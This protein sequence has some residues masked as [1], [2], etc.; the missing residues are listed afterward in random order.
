[1]R[2]A[3]TANG[4]GTS[5]GLESFFLPLADEVSATSDPRIID[6]TAKA[7]KTRRF[8]RRDPKKVYALVLHQM[9]CCFKVSDPLTRFL[10]MA[11]HFAILPDGRILQLHPILSLT[12]AS[13]GFNPG[14]VAVEFAGNFPDTRGKWWHGPQNGQNQVTAAQI[15]AGRYLVRHLMRTMGLKVIVAHRQSSGTRDNDPG[16]DI[17][18]HVGQWAVDNLGL[19]DG[20]PG[21]KTGTGKPIPDLWRTWGKVKPQPELEFSADESEAWESESNRSSSEYIRWVQQG[22][23]R[24]LGLRLAVDGIAGVQTKSAIR[25]FQTRQ[26]LVVDG[27][28][29]PVT[30]ASLVAAGAG[31]APGNSAPPV[32]GSCPAPTFVSCPGPGTTP[33]EVLDNFGHNVATLNRP[34]HTPRINRVAGQITASQSSRHPIRSILIAGHTDPT[35]SDRFNLDLARRRAEAV[36]QELCVAVGPSVARRLKFDLTSCGE[37]HL[38][39]TP[40][41]SRR[42]ELFLPKVP[43][44]S[45]KPPDVPPSAPTVPA[46]LE[47]LIRLVRDIL[48]GI[49]PLLGLTGAKLPTTARFLT[50]PEQA[51]AKKVFDGSLDFS[52]ILIADG[53]GF[54]N[55]KFT[56]AVPVSGRFHVVMLLGDLNPWHTH[57]R[58]ST[59]IHELAHAWQSQ[60]ANDATQFMKNS[61]SCQALALA[62]I[63]IA[64]A[65]AAAAAAARAAARGVLPWEIPGISKNAAANEDVSAYAYIPGKTFEA[66]AAEQIAQQ[67]ED[68]HARTGRPTPGVLSTIKSVRAGARDLKNEAS[69]R[70]VSFHRKSTPGVVFH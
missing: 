36:A 66:Y 51:A 37:Q 16:P 24:I 4:L 39:T 42:V 14:S 12:G 18:Y 28:V 20:G 44:P 47:L 49:T 54:Q 40:E 31:P 69:L 64:K 26:G 62:D 53:T 52:R 25:S 67:V 43:P 35:G 46:D 13:N 30:E 58:S 61:V 8:G 55:R 41:L 5:L 60:H 56:V 29:G 27:I 63:P 23:N 6:L 59:L 70:V 50:A 38:K 9:A 65:A 34:L 10:K 17:W 22:L 68:A 2:N 32:S 57:G 15:E 48:R 3:F 1:M 21:F 19:K 45:S 7:D 33:T 11:P